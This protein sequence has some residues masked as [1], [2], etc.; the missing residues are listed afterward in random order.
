VRSL[1]WSPTGNN[2]ASASDHTVHVWL[3]QDDEK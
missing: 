3:V 2:I 1:N